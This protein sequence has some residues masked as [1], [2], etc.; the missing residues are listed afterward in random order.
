[1]IALFAP[2]RRAIDSLTITGLAV[3]AL[4]PFLALSPAKAAPASTCAADIAAVQQLATT[5]EPQAAAKALRIVRLAEKLCEAG[6]RF[7]AGK[8]LAIAREAVAGNVQ[9]AA[10]R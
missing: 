3:A 5:A 8:K 7:E 2:S 4:L 6:N 10:N 9:M 1:M